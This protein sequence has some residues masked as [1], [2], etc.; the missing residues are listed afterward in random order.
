MKHHRKADTN[1]LPTILTAC[2]LALIVPAAC[3]AGPADMATWAKA[4]AY[5]PGMHK[6]A[7]RKTGLKDCSDSQGTVTCVATNALQIGGITSTDGK[8]ELNAKSGRVE[9]VVFRF[10]ADK[11]ADVSAALIRQY[12]EPTSRDGD[13]RADEWRR[14]GYGSSAPVLLWHRGGDDVLVVCGGNGRRQGVTTV[15]AERVSGRGK[16]WGE[17]TAHRAY[18]RA[19]T[20]SFNSK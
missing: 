17:A 18:S 7:A 14:M 11:F 15:V 1:Y 4:G 3:L 16:E 20:G 10:A 8:I 9:R 6:D 12:G 5:Y 19:T 2:T 13:Y